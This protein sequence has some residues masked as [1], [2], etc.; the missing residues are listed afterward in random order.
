MEAHAARAIRLRYSSTCRDCG[1]P[2]PAGSE[3]VWDPGLRTTV[4]VHCPG[5]PDPFPAA[6]ALVRS[7]VAGRSA[8]AEGDRRRTAR[9]NRIRE[10]FPHIGGLL[11]ALSEP[12]QTTRVW[13]QGAVGERK[14][15]DRL[16]KPAS[17][18][19][20]VVL[21]DRRVFGS[22]ANIDH[23][24]VGPAGVYVVDTK[25][26]LNKKIETRSD[27]SLFSTKPPRLFVDGR[28]QTK[29]VEGM[30]WQVSAVRAAVDALGT[31]TP[32]PTMPVL[33]FVDGEWE[34]FSG[35]FRIGDVHVTGPRGLV[36]HTTR[37][38]E[39]DAHERLALGHHLASR[40]PEA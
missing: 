17:D 12:P 4:C 39:F 22:K 23:I 40:L 29:L 24:V 20:I 9:E 18:G 35:P 7:G 33:C 19:S 34:L 3:A 25:R 16:A 21:H 1:T 2:L 8:Q 28:D 13:A 10:R 11:L 15:A 36:K 37:P 31:G 14:V 38:G 26:Y 32:I 5:P 6:P 27:G 30:A